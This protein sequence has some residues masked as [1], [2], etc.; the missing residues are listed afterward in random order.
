MPSAAQDTDEES[1]Q[2][3][4]PQA[5]PTAQKSAPNEDNEASNAQPEQQSDSYETPAN[6]VLPAQQDRG[7]LTR[8]FAAQGYGAPSKD[9]QG[10]P[11]APPEPEAPQD[12]Q[13]TAYDRAKSNWQQDNP[14]TVQDDLADSRQ[15]I[16]ADLA[17][18]SFTPRSE[19][20]DR[21]LRAADQEVDQEARRPCRT[22]ERSG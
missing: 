12:L 17:G 14:N 4:T 19:P 10:A 2:D 13:K 21:Y 16:E 11:L 18:K 1:E 9:Y 15:G 3:V 5:K 8:S 20:D 7:V 22:P 6:A